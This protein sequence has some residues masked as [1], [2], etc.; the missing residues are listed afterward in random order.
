MKIFKIESKINVNL[1]VEVVAN[2]KQDA[3][4]EFNDNYTDL[5]EI[6]VGCENFSVNH[7]TIEMENID[8]C[9]E[10][11]FAYGDLNSQNLLLNATLEQMSKGMNEFSLIELS[12]SNFKF[13]EN[14]YNSQS[15]S[16]K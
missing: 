4:D 16:L 10:V 15:Q 9:E 13:I 8:D 12:S 3:I 7:H 5:I 1:S 6:Y 2:S 11:E 14:L